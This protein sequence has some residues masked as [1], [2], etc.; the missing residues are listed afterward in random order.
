MNCLIVTVQ[1]V[2]IMLLYDDPLLS[3]FF[4]DAKTAVDP[5]KIS[6]YR[7]KKHLLSDEP[8][9]RLLMPMPHVK[10]LFFAHQV[11]G[12]QGYAVDWPM[13]VAYFPWECIAD[14][15]ITAE[16]HIGIGIL[17]ADCLPIILYDR[18]LS[19]VAV[20]H[21]GWRGSV[22][23]IA[24]IA[25]DHMKK[26][27][28]SKTQSMQVFFG[29]AAGS[30]CYHIGPSV[31]AALGEAT[32]KATVMRSAKTFFDLVGYNKWLLVEAGV[33][34][35]SIIDAYHTC[36]ICHNSYCSYRRQKEAAG[37][38]MTVVCLK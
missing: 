22:S 33:P 29:P 30:C 35:E 17:T 15:L 27:Y 25:L 21:A 3:I 11:H 24:L 7:H 5:S 20:V 23:Q 26:W 37:R 10:K 31:L 38:Q 34:P 6:H 4:G 36:T 8:W 19:V 13:T 9:A 2:V 32:P 16:L 1:T 12:T 28:G 18:D 14:Y